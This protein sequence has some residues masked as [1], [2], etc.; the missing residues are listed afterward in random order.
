MTPSRAKYIW[1]ARAGLPFGMALAALAVS[2]W[3][4]PAGDPPRG[5]AATL[6]A[7]PTGELGVAP[8]DTIA[9]ARELK[10]GESIAGR[11]A[12]TNQTGSPLAVALRAAV[13][14]RDLDERLRLRA[15]IGRRTV[16]D[17]SLG[18][19]RTW[20]SST[21]LGPGESRR[22]ELRLSVPSEAVGYHDRRA[23]VRIELRSK[24]VR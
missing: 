14:S 12:V 17:A 1:P 16:A 2:G 3:T 10:A 20:S 21:V 15:A 9:R 19:A 18:A 7:G 13:P 6:T 11:F 4:V 5:V 24:P 23:D 8:G 22:V